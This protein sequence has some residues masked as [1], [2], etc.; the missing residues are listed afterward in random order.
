[1]EK[2]NES[3]E[4]NETIERSSQLSVSEINKIMGD[5]IEFP[6]ESEQYFLSAYCGICQTTGAL[7]SCKY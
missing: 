7:T 4:L 2:Q 1:M 6:E 3:N 5:I